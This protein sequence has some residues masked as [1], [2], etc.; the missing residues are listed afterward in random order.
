MEA[1]RRRGILPRE[2]RSLSEESLRWEGPDI[3][4]GYEESQVYLGRD[5]GKQMRA[6]NLSGNRSDIYE[7]LK[8][9]CITAH[10]IM[11]STRAY[12]RRITVGLDLD[13]LP[14]EVHSIRPVRRIGPDG[15][16]LM[17]AVV[18][19][20]QRRPGY[21]DCT[22]DQCPLQLADGEE[23]DFW[24]RGGCT[25]IIDLETGRL[26]YCIYKQIN[27]HNRYER[28]R[29][30][31]SGQFSSPSLSATYFEP[32]GFRERGEVFAFVHR[33]HEKE[34]VS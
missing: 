24:F 20:T 28:Q 19:I 22:L 12:K 14:F 5:L 21:V 10:D 4:L 17:D 32:A 8:A 30:F 7:K 31:A 29:A 16:L 27:S 13:R 9:A 2:T 23:P 33:A 11:E 1:F 3:A 18:E 26:R 25:M 15:Q 6:W 34:A